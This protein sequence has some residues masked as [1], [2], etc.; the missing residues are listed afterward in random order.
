MMKRIA[1]Y[2]RARGTCG[3]DRPAAP[4]APARPRRDREAR[5]PARAPAGA[6]PRRPRADLRCLDAPTQHLAVHDLL[7][8]VGQHR[9]RCRRRVVAQARVGGA[10]DEARRQLHEREQLLP[11]HALRQLEAQRLG[12]TPL[13]VHAHGAERRA[14]CDAAAVGA[15]AGIPLL[16]G[17]LDGREQVAALVHDADATL[18]AIG[19]LRHGALH[20]H[21]PDDDE[22]HQHQA[23]QK[24]LAARGCHELRR[25]DRQD[26]VHRL[27]AS[28]SSSAPGP[29]MRTKMSCSEGLVIS[30]WCTR[31]AAT[32]R[33]RNAWGSRRCESPGAA[34]SR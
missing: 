15:H 29:A 19:L 23:E 14:V 9:V 22:R 2:A 32:S 20:D 6:G 13:R 34:R 21:R 10:L 26:P 18:G 7:Q 24:T 25:G 30:K 1:T 4:R 5:A 11:A 16:G 17:T 31:V 33:E 12:L 3:R 27:P 28:D 8:P